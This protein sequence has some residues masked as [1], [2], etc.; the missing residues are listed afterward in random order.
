MESSAHSRRHRFLQA[1]P[2]F[3]AVIVAIWVAAFP[4][5]AFSQSAKEIVSRANTLLHGNSSTGIA[6]MTVI[7]PDWTRQMTTKLWMLEPDY[8][9]ILITDPAKDKGTVTLKRKN[10]IWNWVP[11]IQRIIKIPPSMMMQP[12]MGSDFTNDDLVRESSIVEDYS[13]TLEGEETIDGLDCYKIHLLPKPDAGVVWEKV[14]MWIAKDG[15][16][17]LRTEYYGEDG[18]LIKYMTGSKIKEMGGHTLPSHWEMI[19]KDKPGEK[20]V[21]DYQSMEFDVDLKP[22]FFSRQTMKRVR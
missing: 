3:F 14:I 1:T 11:A 2:P 19:P 17:E 7:K 21:L 6:T 8:A 15:Y 12:W 20:T 13:H 9:M 18:S 4:A 16:Q 10:E 5:L 22:S